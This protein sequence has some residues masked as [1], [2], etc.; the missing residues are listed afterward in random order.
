[1]RP[2]QYGIAVNLQLFQLSLLIA[3][4]F[5]IIPHKEKIKKKPKPKFGRFFL[6]F[7]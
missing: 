5:L 7:K 1:M 6:I 4:R 3:V 2:K